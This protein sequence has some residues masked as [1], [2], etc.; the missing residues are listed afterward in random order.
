M[1]SF[2]ES[3]TKILCWSDIDGRLN[4][5][6]LA[7]PALLLIVWHLVTVDG[8]IPGYLL[9]RPMEIG[10]VA[11]DFALGNWQLTPY[12]GTMLDHSLASISRVFSGFGFAAAAGLPLGFLTGR[13]TAVKRTI[14]PTIHLFRTIPGIG[15]LPVAMV[16]FGVGE[17]TTLFLIALAAFFPIYVNSAQGAASVPPQLIWAGRMLGANKISLFTT[18][19]IPASAPA[20]VAGLRLGMGLSWAYLVLG[21]LTGVA[22]GL[23]AVMMDARMLGHVDMIIV[24]MVCIAIWGRVTDLVLTTMFKLYQ[25]RAGGAVS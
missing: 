15:W 10:K 1:R 5:L 25:P 13:I 9:P 22:Q 19:I 23:G 24:A 16:W 3:G 8:N 17:R 7:L 12:S 11:L 20:V 18:I 2:K 4:P 14:D 21:E 6:G